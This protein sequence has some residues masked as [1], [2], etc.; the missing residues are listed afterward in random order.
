M[1]QTCLP[2]ILL[3][4]VVLAV[5]GGG[6][7]LA[8]DAPT[9]PTSPE[10]PPP[11]PPPPADKAGGGGWGHHG[12]MDKVL[13]PEERAQLKKDTDAVLAADPDLKKESDDLHASM[14]AAHDAG[15]PPSAE[16]KQAMHEKM[17]AYQDKV[18]AAVEKLDPSTTAI[19]AKI[20]AARQAHDKSTPPPQ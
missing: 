16:D 7:L 1:K 11:A 10:T 12:F 13:T 19:Y 17:H 9:P 2:R 14:K 6:A 5:S 8:Q 18:R 4:A 15:T 20:D 3:L